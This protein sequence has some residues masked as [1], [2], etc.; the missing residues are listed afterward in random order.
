MFVIRTT[1]VF[2]ILLKNNDVFK[3]KIKTTKSKYNF[4]L[5][6]NIFQTDILFPNN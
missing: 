1:R 2:H 3:I 5:M 4:Q 6:L